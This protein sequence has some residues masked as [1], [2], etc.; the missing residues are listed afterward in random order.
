[1]AERFP[2]CNGE[3]TRHADG[4]PY[5]KVPVGQSGCVMFGPYELLQPGSYEVTY[6]VS[7]SDGFVSDGRDFCWVDVAAN[8]AAR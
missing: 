1:V 7:P 8:I 5:V 2:N 3:I 4:E 6:M